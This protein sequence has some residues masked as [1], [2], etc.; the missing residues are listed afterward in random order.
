MVVPDWVFYPLAA[1]IAGAIILF[2]LNYWPGRLKGESPFVGPPEQGFVVAAEQLQILQ[3]GPGLS[4]QIMEGG[5]GFTL[6]VAAGHGP[7][8]GDK[9]AGVFLT[10]PQTYSSAFADKTV[11]LTMIVRAAGANPSPQVFIG[12][13]ATGRAD[14]P[15]TFCPLTAHW[16]ACRLLFHVPAANNNDDIDFVG[17]W[18]DP[19]GLSRTA[20]I[21]EV[22][23]RLIASPQTSGSE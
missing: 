13:Y 8:D 1:L 9:S 16:Q 4:A 15:R 17:I 14:S 20:D 22:Q 2:S 3:A 11:E 7:D 5:D 19:D 18:P 23:V 6:R 10:L 21:R 12:Y